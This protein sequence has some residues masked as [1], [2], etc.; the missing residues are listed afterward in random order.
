M[1]SN[2]TY[3]KFVAA[4]PEMDFTPIDYIHA[5]SKFTKLPD[6]FYLFMTKMLWPSFFKIEGVIF[7][8]E[9]FNKSSYDEYVNLG[10]STEKSQPWVNQIEITSIFDGIKIDAA[11]QIAELIVAIWNGKLEI[12][13]GRDM[14][15]A[16]V[17]VDLELEEVFVTIGNFEKS[18]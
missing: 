7:I 16:T 1:K 12:E 15:L 8:L 14:R 18:A 10:Y 5:I 11:K 6:D 2:W 13:F 4:N 9:T 17:A 3:E